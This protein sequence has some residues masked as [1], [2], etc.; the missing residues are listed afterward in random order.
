MEDNAT[1]TNHAGTTLYHGYG[2]A[3][4]IEGALSD[5]SRSGGIRTLFGGGIR[6][7]SKGGGRDDNNFDSIPLETRN[8][9]PSGFWNASRTNNNS[10]W[11]TR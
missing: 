5:E 7:S 9:P 4:S 2:G 1:T 11:V 3:T 10:R 6:D 8:S